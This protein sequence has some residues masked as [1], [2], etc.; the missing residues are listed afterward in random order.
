M[1]HLDNFLAVFAFG[2]CTI[3]LAT[4]CMACAGWAYGV[5]GTYERELIAVATNPWHARDV[6]AASSESSREEHEPA[7]VRLEP[8]IVVGSRRDAETQASQVA[9]SAS[10]PHGNS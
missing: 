2:L 5:L 8:I 4:F 7:V 9:Q 6:Y 1:K 3:T 10:A